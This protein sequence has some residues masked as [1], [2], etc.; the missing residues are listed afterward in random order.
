MDADGTLI[1]YSEEILGLGSLTLTLAKGSTTGKTKV[2]TVSPAATGT[3]TY[4]YKIDS[5]AQS[6][7]YDTVLTVGWTTITPG[8]TDIAATAGQIITVAEID[9]G[10]K[11][12]A[13]GTVTVID[14]IA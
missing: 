3:N 9:S 6:V 4:V 5:V 8:T 14:N 13:V 10:N 7:T 11:A 1:M 12:K 2:N